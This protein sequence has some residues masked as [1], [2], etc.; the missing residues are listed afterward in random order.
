MTV[1]TR[2]EGTGFL[3]IHQV[4]DTIDAKDPAAVLKWM[5]EVEASQI[6]LGECTC[7]KRPPCAQCELSHDVQVCD[8]CGNGETWYGTP[9]Q[10]YTSDDPQGPDGPYVGNGGLCQCH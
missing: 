1:C 5:D 10:H 8:C 6:I 4:P 3:N 7:H 9:G 2:C